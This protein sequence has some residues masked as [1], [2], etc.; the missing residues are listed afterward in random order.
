MPPPIHTPSVYLFP[1]AQYNPRVDGA[2][3]PLGGLISTSKLERTLGDP[4]SLIHARST[5]PGNRTQFRLRARSPAG[6]D[7][8]R[9]VSLKI[10]LRR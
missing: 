5:Q 2:L 9:V 8:G 7:P 1:A 4:S 3:R 6:G 10:K